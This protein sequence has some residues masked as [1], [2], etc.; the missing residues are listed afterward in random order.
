MLLGACV[1]IAQPVDD[2]SDVAVWTFNGGITEDWH[3]DTAM[4]VNPQY[5]KRAW[6]KYSE[7]PCNYFTDPAYSLW[8][9]PPYLND[10]G[11]LFEGGVQCAHIQQN[12]G[13]PCDSDYDD[14][15]L[16]PFEVPDPVFY[17]FATRNPDDSIYWLNNYTYPKC[18]A[19]IANENWRDFLL[20][21]A[22]EQ[23]DASVNALEFD[24]INAGYRFTT[25]GTPDDNSNDG[26]DDYAIGIANFANKLSVVCGHG[27]IDPIEWFMPTTSASSNSDSAHL[28]FDDDFATLWHSE[29]GDTHWLEIDFGRIRTIQQI[30]LRFPTEHILSAFYVLYWDGVA[31]QDFDSPV[32]DML[33][34]DSIRSFLVEPAP[35]QKVMLFSTDSEAYISE[36]QLFGQGFR[37]FI[38]KRYCTDSGWTADDTRWEY[39][40]LIDFSDSATCHDGTMNSFNYRRYLQYHGWAGNPF[41]AEITATNYLNPENPLFFDW[42]PYKYCGGLM[43]IFF[44]DS[45]IFSIIETLFVASYSYQRT[46]PNFWFPAMDS[47]RA[48][49]ASLGRDIYITRNGFLFPADED[50]LLC[51]LGAHPIFPVLNEPSAEDS[52]KVILDG[53]EARI[54]IWR[55]IKE[56][57][58][59][60]MGRD[61]PLVA[62]CD[63]ADHMPFAHLGGIDEPADE[64][65]IYLRTYPMEM[66]VAGVNFC[67]PVVESEE[68]AWLDSTSDGTAII[69]VIKQQ[70][71]FL[72]TYIHIYRDVTISD[73]ETLVT[74]NGIVPYNGEW[75]WDWGMIIS[76][77]NESK[78][79]IAYTE[80]EIEERAYLHIIN[81][82]WDSAGRMMLPQDSIPVTIPVSDTCRVVMIISPD[83]PDTL[84]PAFDYEDGVVSLVIPILEY[85]N[86]II[87]DFADTTKITEKT[88]KLPTGIYISVSPNPF[89]SSCAISAPSGAKIEIYDLRGTLRL[90]SVPDGSTGSPTGHHGH[91]ACRDAEMTA[92]REFI[93]HPDKSITSGIYLIKATMENGLI[94]TKRI[95]YLQ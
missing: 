22:Y 72:N 62:F 23:I 49:A 29:A 13:W 93:W 50:Y 81:H 11:A 17:D 85:Y 43:N 10:L 27:I 92:N 41:G 3:A 38:L 69:D 52:H 44:A 78:V 79:T 54:N 5:C 83:F 76:P 40:K 9:I 57:T 20:Y 21:W 65:A 71:D 56:Y 24:Q 67:Y 2:L 61:V 70:T 1:C 60:S 26:Y 15:H 53:S 46:F 63:F 37:Q 87:L 66:R 55:M 16:P 8:T 31:W 75:N 28:A 4:Y 18:N 47:M 90:R 73:A 80:S 12:T 89:N 34:T 19:S 64:R 91:R 74:V 7:I 14:D 30:Y 51:P 86:I 77:V 68:I 42:G 45:S 33:N 84:Y 48:Y 94:K 32:F 36:M 82:D 6:F 25:S 39:E 35:A 95:V 59:S 88:P 58:V